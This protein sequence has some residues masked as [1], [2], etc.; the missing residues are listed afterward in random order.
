ML[1]SGT[2]DTSGVILVFLN[3]HFFLKDLLV[4][5]M[6]READHYSTVWMDPER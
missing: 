2:T 6:D 3:A 4:W 5:G 1:E